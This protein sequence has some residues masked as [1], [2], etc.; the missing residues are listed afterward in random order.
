[1]TRIAIRALACALFCLFVAGPPL[2]LQA[3]AAPSRTP[4]IHT[5]LSTLPGP[6]RK[7]REAILEAAR[8]GDITALHPVVEMNE[9]KPTI[10]FGDANDPIA[11]WKKTSGDGQ[12]REI[13][14]IMVEILE[15]PFA[16]TD[17]GTSNEMYVWPYL[18]VLPPAKLNPAQQIDL[19]RL[20]TPDEAKNMK[21]FG[22]YIHY[23]LGL[24]PDGTWHFFVA[25]D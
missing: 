14:A 15:M 3:G 1:M 2:A 10:S 7:M 24:G 12:G 23:R 8:S 21:E 13:M 22:S 25:G 19:Y 6:V 17:T 18:A 5:D 16:R 9:L 11:Y 20:M 4:E